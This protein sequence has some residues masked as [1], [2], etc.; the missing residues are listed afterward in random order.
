MGFSDNYQLIGARCA[1]VLEPAESGHGES[2]QKDSNEFRLP[3]S[4]GL[5]E[6]LGEAGAGSP[7][8]NA[9]SRGRRPQILAVC[10]QRRKHRFGLRK[11][12]AA[13]KTIERERSP[14]LGIRDDDTNCGTEGHQRGIAARDRRDKDTVSPFSGRAKRAHNAATGAWRR[15]HRKHS[16][17]ERLQL[18]IVVLAC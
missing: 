4:L 6:N 3:T 10:K 16:G 9:E 13:A 15:S 14:G 11:T 1:A 2:S 18:V 7:I 8:R 12:E 5:L 17:N